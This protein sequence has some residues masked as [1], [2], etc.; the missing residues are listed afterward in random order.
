[1]QNEDCEKA[2]SVDF[3]QGKHVY[4]EWGNDVDFKNRKM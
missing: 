1:V 4:F 3:D 2:K